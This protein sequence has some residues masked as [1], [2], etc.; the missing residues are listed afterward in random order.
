M[1]ELD[2][3]SAKPFMRGLT[4]LGSGYSI[5]PMAMIA[6]FLLRPL[7]PASAA[8][9]PMLTAGGIVVDAVLKWVIARP[10]PNSGSFGFPSGH[11]FLSV[12]FFGAVLYLVWMFERGKPWRWGAGVFCGVAVLGIAVSRLSLNAHWLSDVVGGAAGGAAY[13]LFALAVGGRRLRSS[14]AT[15][16]VVS[17]PA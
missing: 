7:Q 6:C 1:R 4:Y 16:H 10:R 5:I 3:P 9:I 2:I 11:V 12:V 17:T 13:L 15:G 14:D 8:L